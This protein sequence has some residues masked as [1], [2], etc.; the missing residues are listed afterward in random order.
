MT[1]AKGIR[2][3]KPRKS[4]SASAKKK[5]KLNIRRGTS[6]A[7]T[8]KSTRGKKRPVHALARPKKRKATKDATA[9][10]NSCENHWDA[11]KSDCS[12]FVKAVAADF[13]I[14]LTGQADDIVDQMQSAPWQTLSDG[15]SAKAQADSGNFV[16]AGLKGADHQPPRDHGHVVVVVTGALAQNKYPTAYWGTLGG[17]G[18]KNTTLNWAWNATDRDNVIYAYQTLT[19]GFR[20]RR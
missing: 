12:G 17:T 20:T 16:L 3:R 18:R 8:R 11:Y 14:N 10:V 7:S 1:T 15:P 4:R 6:E 13:G 2:R 5:A 9:I 19:S